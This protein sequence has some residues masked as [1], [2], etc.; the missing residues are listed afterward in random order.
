MNGLGVSHVGA[1]PAF[2]PGPA[3]H[4]HG[5][6]DFN[7]DGK[8]DI[9]WQDDNSTGRDVADGRLN[10]TFVGAVGPFNPGPSWHIKGTG[11]FNGDGKADILWQN[12]NGTAASG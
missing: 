9:L 11:D 12:D 3:W 10:T 4:V 7:G 5:S 6:G 2:N 8:A 1:L